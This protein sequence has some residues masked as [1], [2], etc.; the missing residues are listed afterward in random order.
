MKRTELTFPSGDGRCA[1]WLY[2][3]A[4]TTRQPGQRAPCIVLAH[5]FGGVREARLGAFAERF[6]AAGI[7]ALVFDYRHFGASSGEPRQLLDIRRQLAD[8]RSA[9]AV[10]R[11]LPGIDPDRIA[12]WGTSFSGGHVAAIAARD[13]RLAAAI[14]QNPFI[15]GL[16]TLR[17]MGPRNA[18]RLARAGLRDELRRPPLTIPIV[19]PPGSVAAMSTPDAEPGYR[20]MFEPHHEFRN[21]ILARIALRVGTYR[22]GRRAHRIRCPWLIAVCDNDTITPPAPAIAAARR[23]PAGELRSYPAGHVDIY[24]AATFDHAIADQIAFLRQRLLDTPTNQHHAPT[25]SISQPHLVG[26]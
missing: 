4:P 20:A 11:S 22:P 12:V 19:G 3:A 21:E 8:W 18:L 25:A 26:R 9:I 6:A 13:P 10:A 17:A 16:P 24:Q 23:A 14:S 5:G 15:D 1:A 2:Q 7:A